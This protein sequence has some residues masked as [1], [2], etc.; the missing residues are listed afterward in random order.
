M[1]EELIGRFSPESFGEWCREKFDRF[2]ADPHEAPNA[3]DFPKARIVGYVQ[4]LPD[5]DINR[6][7]LVMSVYAGEQISERSS[8]RKQF[9]FARKQLL[10]AIDK[11]P[12]KVKGLFTQG[13]F[14]FHD[15]AGNFRLSLVSARADGKKLVYSDFKRQSFFIRPGLNNKTFRARM[16]SAFGTYGD[17]T[18][19]ALPPGLLMRS[20]TARTSSSSRA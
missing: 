3:G 13:L 2:T 16:G 18:A 8:R 14:A 11:P 19:G 5:S 20:T 9:D 15:K 12:A 6:P 1:I 10:A 7:L 17:L 4:T